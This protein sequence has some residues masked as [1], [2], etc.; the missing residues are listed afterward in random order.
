MKLFSAHAISPELVYEGQYVDRGSNKGS[1]VFLF[2]TGGRKY[3]TET[4]RNC[5]SRRHQGRRGACVFHF[6]DYKRSMMNRVNV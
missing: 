3:E 5:D 1:H 4:Y 2:L 6:G